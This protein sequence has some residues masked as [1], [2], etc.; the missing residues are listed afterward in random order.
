MQGVLERNIVSLFKQLG[1]AKHAQLYGIETTM[2][3]ETSCTA[4]CMSAP[5]PSALVCSSAAPTQSRINHDSQFFKTRYSRLRNDN[6]DNV[7]SR[8]TNYAV[9]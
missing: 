3:P 5:L 2:Q 1:I 4:S 7:S 6:F 9:V 8:S